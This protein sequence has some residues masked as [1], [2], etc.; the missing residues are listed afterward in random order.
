MSI[1]DTGAVLETYMNATERSGWFT[2]LPC[3]DTG[4]MIKLL[5]RLLWISVFSNYK[6]FIHMSSDQFYA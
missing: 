1:L 5:N 3:Y 4:H 2:R 6:I